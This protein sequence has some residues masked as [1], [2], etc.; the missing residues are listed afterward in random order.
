VR[1]HGITLLFDKIQNKCKE[2]RPEVVANHVSNLKCSDVLPS[3]NR[4]GATLIT[5]SIVKITAMLRRWH[6]SERGYFFRERGYL[7]RERGYL[8]RERGYLSTE[9]GY[10]SR[11]RGYLSTERGYLSRVRG[12]LS[13]VRGYLSRVRGCHSRVGWRGGEGDTGA[14]GNTKWTKPGKQQRLS[15]CHVN[16][17]TSP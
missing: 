17:T 2:D 8:S 16:V 12:Y 3:T 9:R 1:G 10:L 5:L 11:V 4:Y 13:R 7:S 6:D 15:N 14:A